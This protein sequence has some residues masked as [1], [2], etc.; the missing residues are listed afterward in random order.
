MFGGMGFGGFGGRGGRGG[1]DEG[2][3]RTPDVQ[4]QL[5]LSLRD[6]YVG[7]K[8][9]LKIQRRVLCK[10]CEGK[11]VKPGGKVEKC[12]GC[13][14]A[15]V[16]MIVQ[17]L[18]PGMIQQMQTQCDECGGKGEV[19]DPKDACP[20]CKGKKTVPESK[21]LEVYVRPGMQPGQKITFYGDADEE[22]G[23]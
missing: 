18:G 2:P 15:G 21:I 14:G 13:N 16:R 9:K 7:R 5:G 8:K 4:F 10:A 1:R 6:F 20:E 12:K 11:G 22:Y 3:K 19:I 23:R 17:R